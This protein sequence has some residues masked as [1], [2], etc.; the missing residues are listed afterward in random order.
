MMKVTEGQ[1]NLGPERPRVYSELSQEEKDRIWTC[2]LLLEGSLNSKFVNNML[3]NGEI[4]TAV[5]HNKGLKDSTLI[6]Y[7]SDEQL[8]EHAIEGGLNQKKGKSARGQVK[9]VYGRAT[10]QS[11]NANPGQARSSRNVVVTLDEE[12]Y[13]S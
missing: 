9:L 8:E 7:M 10:E 12:Q 3:R 11:G 2:E 13:C 1:I 6:K 5:K 4:V